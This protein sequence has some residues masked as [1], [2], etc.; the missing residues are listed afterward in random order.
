MVKNRTKFA[1]FF[2]LLSGLVTAC[3]KSTSDSYLRHNDN[4][5][6]RSNSVWNWSE[7]S[8]ENQEKIVLAGEAPQGFL[9][10]SSKLVKRSQYWVD[11]IDSKMRSAHS[12][13]MAGVPKPKVKLLKVPDFNAFIAGMYSCFDL[14]L[15]ISDREG[16]RDS[17]IFIDL[18]AGGELY[19]WNDTDA[20]FPV[21]CIKDPSKETLIQALAEFNA[22]SASCKFEVRE[23]KVVASADCPVAEEMNSPRAIAAGG[24]IVISR[25]SSW[26]NIFTGLIE[27]IAD[28][29]EFVAVIAHELAHYYRSHI[30]ANKTDYD[31][32]YLLGERNPNTRPVERSDLRAFGDEVYLSSKIVNT[33][34]IF[35]KIPAQKL[36]AKIYLAAGD[37]AR[38]ACELGACASQ[39]RTVANLV[40]DTAYRTN[41][42]LY[43][44][45]A[46]VTAPAIYFEKFETNALACLA[47]VPYSDSSAITEEMVLAAIEGPV[48]FG[49][50][51]NQNFYPAG[52]RGVIRS[53]LASIAGRSRP[54]PA[55]ANVLELLKQLGTKLDAQLPRAMAAMVQ[56]RDQ[57]LGQYTAEQE[58]DELAVEWTTK[59]GLPPTSMVKANMMIASLS[60]EDEMNG[61]LFGG[62]SCKVLFDNDWADAAG[63]AVFVPIG[64]YSEVHHSAC[65]R[66]FNT[67]RELLAHSYVQQAGDQSTPP[68][69]TWS[70]V[71]AE[72]TRVNNRLRALAAPTGRRVQNVQGFAKR[73]TARLN[74]CAISQEH[75]Q[76]K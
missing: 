65:F 44:F 50:A 76:G 40:N 5:P 62:E 17:G 71:K 63:T 26:V 22:S 73:D 7:V 43:P 59:I 42:K 35:A 15:E 4:Q 29:D 36:S 10:N 39:C 52:V 70:A 60:P 64:D 38:Q 9:S 20:D 45:G 69:G 53:L 46:G 12:Q 19:R 51:D 37:L 30:T 21:E 74:S 66:A 34:P 25:T 1:A 16:S 24:K 32:F 54:L 2:F 18:S 48:W 67:Q 8:E 47:T 27:K 56:A 41:N 75:S 3:G 55:A 49:A 11:Q 23:N 58:A 33:D 61:L 68:G 28:E 6:T 14:S 72:A 57:K 13:E 31:F